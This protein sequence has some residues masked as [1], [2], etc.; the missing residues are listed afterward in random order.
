MNKAE[1]TV[2]IEK[3]EG[4]AQASLILG[5]EAR[6]QA[7]RYNDLADNYKLLADTHRQNADHFR[8]MRDNAE[9]PI[10]VKE[11]K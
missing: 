6:E 8:K 9:T 10:P 2:A 7:Q 5:A 1:M 11:V 3:F 4:E